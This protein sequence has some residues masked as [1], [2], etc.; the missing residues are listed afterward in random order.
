MFYFYLLRT[1][2]NTLYTGVTSNLRDRENRHNTGR[3]SIWTTTHHGGK[4]VYTETFP[5]LSKA[6][7][8]ETQ[9]KKWSRV[10]KENLIKMSKVKT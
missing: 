5:T 1:P 3:G 4:I 8:R 10:K 6:R 9:V 7:L 2:N